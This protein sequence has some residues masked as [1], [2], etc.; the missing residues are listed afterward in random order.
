MK[1]LDEAT[2]TALLTELKENAAV[3]GNMLTTEQVEEAL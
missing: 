2:F 1:G 3:Q